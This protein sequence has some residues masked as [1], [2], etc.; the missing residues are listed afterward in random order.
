MKHIAYGIT[1]VGEKR[2]NN[3]DSFLIVDDKNLYLVA[4][5][6]GGHRAGEVASSKAVQ[7][8]N[9]HFTHKRISLI[10]SDRD[11]IKKELMEAVLGAHTSILEEA[12]KKKEHKGMGTTIV[13]AL[14]YDH[15][16]HTC[17]VGDSRAYVINSASIQQVTNDHSYVGE[18]LRK[19]KMSAK[20]ARLSHFKNQITQALGSPYHIDPEYNTC[21][22]DEDSRILLC[23]DGLWDMLS[24][25]EIHR[26]VMTDGSLED[27][28]N[29]LVKKA[30]Q[31]GGKDN[32]TLILINQFRETTTG[33]IILN[34]Q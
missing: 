23:S 13:A 12:R 1:D 9:R 22:V 3:E 18:L 31:A 27:I 15:V 17:H 33:T 2:D 5:G 16:L 28:C 20:E 29:N 24:D 34:Q 10:Q 4:D 11:L 6:M 14:L 25:E 32:I 26:T 8:V 19:G 7:S 21:S 30:N